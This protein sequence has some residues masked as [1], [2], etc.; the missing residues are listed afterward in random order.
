MVSIFKDEYLLVLF[1][2]FLI[3]VKSIYYRYLNK[4]QS[5]KYKQAY[6]IFVLQI[7]ITLKYAK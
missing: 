4:N 2:L 3:M 7:I 5:K 1:S 6:R